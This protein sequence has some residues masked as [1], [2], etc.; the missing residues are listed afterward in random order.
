MGII[1]KTAS[2]STLGL[3][4]FRSK[5]ERLRRAEAAHD[6]ATAELLAEQSARSAADRRV[7]AA[8]RRAHAAELAALHEAKVADKRSRKLKAA[9]ADRGRRGRR[10]AA[11]R[12]RHAEASMRESVSGLVSAAQPV[13]EAGGRS[14]RRHGK[15]ARRRAERTAAIVGPKVDELAQRAKDR[16]SDLADKARDSIDA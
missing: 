11:K 6:A 9:K 12:A 1:R 2:I 13:L 7:A 3:I 8:E 5:K 15:A 16:A 10:K 14:A 4:S